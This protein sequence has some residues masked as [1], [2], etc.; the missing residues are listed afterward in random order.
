M[1]SPTDLDLKYEMILRNPQHT[2]PAMIPFLEFNGRSSNGVDPKLVFSGSELSDGTSLIGIEM[3]NVCGTG[4][5]AP[6]AAFTAV[7]ENEATSLDDFTCGPGP[8][9]MAYS[10]LT[11]P[12][13]PV[14]TSPLEYSVYERDENNAPAYVIGEVTFTDAD[15]P[16]QVS[17]SVSGTDGSYLDVVLGTDNKYQLKISKVL[18][19]TIFLFVINLC[20][21]NPIPK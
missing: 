13:P 5:S 18:Y 12:R 4:T 8:D 21:S 10:K 6:E 16:A 3:I 15:N 1:A 14:L 7:F 2:G 20:K 11:H 17:F 19:D 9:G